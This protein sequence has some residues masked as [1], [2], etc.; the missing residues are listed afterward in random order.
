M[1]GHPT[2]VHN[3]QTTVKEN[4]TWSHSKTR[5]ARGNL[6]EA[7]H[8]GPDVGDCLGSLSRGTSGPRW[9]GGW[10][11]DFRGQRSSREVTLS[12][13]CAGPAAGPVQFWSCAEV[14]QPWFPRGQGQWR[15]WPRRMSPSAVPWASLSHCLWVLTEPSPPW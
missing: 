6:T 11:C 4:H 9:Y 2:V 8:K 15:G 3:L 5:S 14:T 12:L 10:R 1:P 7:G 13:T